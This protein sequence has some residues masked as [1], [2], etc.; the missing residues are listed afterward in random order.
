MIVKSLKFRRRDN[1]KR[2]RESEREPPGSEIVSSPCLGREVRFSWLTDGDLL[3]RSILINAIRVHG[4]REIEIKKAG[5][6]EQ[7]NV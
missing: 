5:E 7:N 1:L 6:Q 3:Q 4:I 2:E